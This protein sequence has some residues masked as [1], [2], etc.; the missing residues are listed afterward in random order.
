MY[1]FNSRVRYSEV[2]EDK[3]LTLNS[4]LSYFQDC[5]TFHS[6]AVGVG[7]DFLERRHQIWVLSSW[8]VVVERYADLCEEIQVGTWAYAFNGFIGM[9]NFTMHSKTGERLAYANTLWAFL[10][11]EKGRPVKVPQDVVDAYTIEEKL[12]MDYAPRKIMVPEGAVLEE[13]FPVHK[14]HLDTNH[15]VNNVQYIQMARDYLPEKFQIRQVRAEYKKQAVLGNVIYPRVMQ[16]E[17]CCTV[18]LCDEA[19]RPYTVV[20]FT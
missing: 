8:Q 6:E 10:D 13:A 18:A 5:S 4:V 16:S 14:S 15:H 2:G 3:K 17:G 11:T 1:S 20:E 7:V 19:E 9:R 12:S